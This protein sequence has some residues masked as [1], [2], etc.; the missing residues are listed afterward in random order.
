MGRDCRSQSEVSNLQSESTW[1]VRMLHTFEQSRLTFAASV[2]KYIIDIPTA[3]K[4]PRSSEENSN[5]FGYEKFYES[6]LQR[7]KDDQS[8]RYF[9]NINRIAKEFPAAHSAEEGKKVKVWCSNDYVRD[10]SF[11]FRP[12]ETDKT[13]SWVWE[14]TRS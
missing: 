6:V 9:R 8:Y 10:H 3:P 14:E 5:R 12:D 2:S 11:S 4:E 1:L 7:K 13:L